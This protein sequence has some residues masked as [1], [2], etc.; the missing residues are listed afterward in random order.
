[1]PVD[2]IT[3]AI[4][5]RPSGAPLHHRGSQFGPAERRK[6]DRNLVAKLLI[7]A[8]ALDRRTRAKEQHGRLL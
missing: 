3:G 1:L 7:F 2:T 5:R 4:G 8:E 6:L